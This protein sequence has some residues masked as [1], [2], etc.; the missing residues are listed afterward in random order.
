VRDLITALAICN[1]VTPVPDDPELKNVLD[2]AKGAEIKGRGTVQHPPRSSNLDQS[3]ALRGSNLRSNNSA[4]RLSNKKSDTKMIL[5]ASSPD[6]IALVKYS[7]SIKM[8]LIERDRTY[9]QIQ[10]C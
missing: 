9:V 6:E 3:P 8:T 4:N 2:V 10:N 7:N 1:N 5:Q